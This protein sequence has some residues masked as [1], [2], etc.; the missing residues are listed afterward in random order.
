MAASATLMMAALC[1]LALCSI[2]S[3]VIIAHA[4]STDKQDAAAG[5]ALRELVENVVAE[6]LGLS[7]GGGGDLGNVGDACPA[8]CQNCLILCAIKCVLKPSPVACYADCIIKD[9]C[10]P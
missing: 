3:Q 2:G 8:A 10:F 1:M 9:A 6:E 4:S 5:A 7:G